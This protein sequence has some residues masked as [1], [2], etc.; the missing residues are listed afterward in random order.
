VKPPRKY[1]EQSMLTYNST[2][3]LPSI[4]ER[5]TEFNDLPTI[6]VPTIKE[7]VPQ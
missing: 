4:Q 6:A 7:I 1:S 5:I 2:T 3:S